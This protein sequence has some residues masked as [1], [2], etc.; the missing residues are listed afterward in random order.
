MAASSWLALGLIGTGALGML[1]FGTGAPA[2]FANSG[3]AH[4]ADR[5]VYEFACRVCAFRSNAQLSY[6]V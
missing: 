6:Q 5:Q 2:I 3:S 1:I 4:R